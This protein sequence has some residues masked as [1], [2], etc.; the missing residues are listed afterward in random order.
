MIEGAGGRVQGESFEA[1][2]APGFAPTRDDRAN[3]PEDVFRLLGPEP[4]TGR[5]GECAGDG[6]LLLVCVDGS[7][8]QSDA[9]PLRHG[10]DVVGR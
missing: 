2:W 3:R 6:R 9:I 8:A 7:L 5:G 1:K 10:V 4:K